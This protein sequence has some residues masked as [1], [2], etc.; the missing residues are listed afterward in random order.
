MLAKGQS[1]GVLRVDISFNETVY[2]WDEVEVHVAD[3]APNDAAQQSSVIFAYSVHELVAEKLRAILQ[4]KLRNRYRRQDIYDIARIVSTRVF[5]DDD[6]DTIYRT[7]LAKCRS[8][9][10][11]PTPDMIDDVELYERSRESYAEMELDRGGRP[12]D[13]DGDFSRVAH[14]YRSLPW[15]A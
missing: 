2:N 15:A 14:F 6:I 12:L 9:N 5:A 8:R 11:E 1:S 7:L 10:I 4:Q 13:F 3:T